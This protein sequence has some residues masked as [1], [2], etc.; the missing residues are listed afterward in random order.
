MQA[1]EIPRIGSH[2]DTN[3][4]AVG[5]LVSALG[6]VQE[7]AEGPKR[8][9]W[10]DQPVE[11]VLDF[12]QHYTAFATPSFYN[13]CEVLRGYI[14]ERVQVAE[15]VRWTIAIVSKRRDA[16]DAVARIQSLEV[17]LVTRRAKSGYPRE[18]FCTQAVVGSADEAVDLSP[19]E[20]AAAIEGSD[21]KA[22]MNP[23]RAAVRRARPPARGLLLL[24]LIKDTAEGETAE[25]IPSVAISFPEST[26]AKPL[27]YTVNPVWKREHGLSEDGHEDVNASESLG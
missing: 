22:P 2:A 19:Q 27:A 9:V 15:L 26:T 24:Y 12:L 14:R 25:F 16:D 7:V 11:L 13:S 23:E 1:L 3:R 4:A 5:H 10:R 20:R 6:S 17:P 18:Q 8:F 21:A